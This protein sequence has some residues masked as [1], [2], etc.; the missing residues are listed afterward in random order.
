MGSHWDRQAAERRPVN[1]R[2]SICPSWFIVPVSK[3]ETSHRHPIMPGSKAWSSA[4]CTTGLSSPVSFHVRS[5]TS[6]AEL[7]QLSPQ[8]TADS[9]HRPRHERR[10]TTSNP[11][12]DE[13]RDLRLPQGNQLDT[14]IQ[15]RPRFRNISTGRSTHLHAGMT[16]FIQEPATINEHVVSARAHRHRPP[17]TGSPATTPTGGQSELAPKFQAGSRPPIKNIG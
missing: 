12:P 2:E 17:I 9:L 4:S 7:C 8:Q 1:V 13:R 16:L 5:P 11:D 14:A 15:F 10:V 6:P 3:Q